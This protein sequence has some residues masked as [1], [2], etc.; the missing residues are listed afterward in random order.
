MN[1]LR[2]PRCYCPEPYD[3]DAVDLVLFSD[4][5]ERAF[6]AIAYLWY[7]LCDGG[8]RIAFMMAQS[9]VAPGRYTSM[10]R[11]EL[12]ACLKAKRMGKVVRRDLRIKIRCVIFLTDSTTNLRWFNSKDGRFTPYVGN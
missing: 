11:L 2:I 4:A 3:E 5:S 9:K 8:V 6:G 12:C 10:P 7:E 1:E